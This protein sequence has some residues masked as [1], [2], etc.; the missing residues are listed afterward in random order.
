MAVGKRLPPPVPSS[1]PAPAVNGSGVGADRDGDGAG[2]KG[3]TKDVRRKAL[4]AL[5]SAVRNYQPAMDVCAA[6][7][8]RQGEAEH[9]GDEGNRIDAT[10]MDAVDLVING[11]KQKVTS[12]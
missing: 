4:Y 9:V 8:R 10:D 5:S 7:L 12:V 11:L 1:S 2:G 3:E 6:E